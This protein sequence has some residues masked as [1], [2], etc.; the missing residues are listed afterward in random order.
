MIIGDT[1]TGGANSPATNVALEAESEIPVGLGLSYAIAYLVA[2]GWAVQVLGYKVPAAD[3][4]AISHHS[5]S[6][7][8]ALHHLGEIQHVVE[9]LHDF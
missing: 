4:H 9:V 3:D 5:R 1:G 8:A 2:A 7:T 6:K